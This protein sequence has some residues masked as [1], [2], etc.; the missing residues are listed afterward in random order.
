MRSYFCP[1][2]NYLQLEPMSS[3]PFQQLLFLNKSL[4]A[5][6]KIVKNYTKKERKSLTKVNKQSRWQAFPN[7]TS[8][9]SKKSFKN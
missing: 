4:S 2:R 5:R 7:N 3:L 8:K 9:T 6:K 1:M